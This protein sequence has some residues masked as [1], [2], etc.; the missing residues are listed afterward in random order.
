[1]H[2]PI[3]HQV[4]DAAA[5]VVETLKTPTQTA[6]STTS[7][8]WSNFWS[9][10][11]GSHR[12]PGNAAPPEGLGNLAEQQLVCKGI[13]PL[14]AETPILESKTRVW[15]RSGLRAMVSSQLRLPVPKFH[16]HQ[17]PRPTRPQQE[18]PACRRGEPKA[19][20]HPVMPCWMPYCWEHS[21]CKHCKRSNLKKHLRR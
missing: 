14:L 17:L 13:P 21:S 20:P 1:M 19:L 4:H 15:A 12:L 2:T 9:G 10:L 11:Q 8:F 18:W 6:A 16:R 7:G 3:A 5:Q